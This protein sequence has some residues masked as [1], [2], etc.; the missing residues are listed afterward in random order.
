MAPP[1]NFFGGL[2]AG[3]STFGRMLAQE[4][5]RRKEEWERIN[6]RRDAQLERENEAA[7]AA[8]RFAQSLGLQREQ[9]GEETRHNKALEALQQ[10]NSFREGMNDMA[11][12]YASQNVLL[13]NPRAAYAGAQMAGIHPGTMGQATPDTPNVSS[14]LSQLQAAGAGLRDKYMPTP[15]AIQKAGVEANKIQAP[16]AIGEAGTYMYPFNKAT[17]EAQLKAAEYNSNKLGLD[18]D[19]LIAAKVATV[20]RAR[21]NAEDVFLK[22]NK[23]GMLPLD[24]PMKPILRKIGI[25]AAKNAAEALG[26]TVDDEGNIRNADGAVIQYEV[27]EDEVGP[28]LTPGAD[29][30]VVPGADEVPSQ[31]PPAP[32]K[33][34][35]G[36]AFVVPKGGSFRG[37]SSSGSSVTTPV[38]PTALP[39]WAK[40]Y[41]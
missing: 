6:A 25:E 3:L 40:K 29:A 18:Q 22:A 9:F 37:S 35:F 28:Q 21:K 11:R 5:I 33:G 2:G 13:S 39:A 31:N 16:T 34:R 19:R 32:G 8:Q 20:V 10:A 17:N 7:A 27:P 26:L 41:Q 4:G 12:T 23:L 38:D 30:P 15:Q 24:D 36:K 14:V 1:Y